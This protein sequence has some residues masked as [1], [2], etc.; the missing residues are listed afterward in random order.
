MNTLLISVQKDLDIIG[1][2]CLHYYLLKNGY[3]S[4]LLHL[5][6]FNPNDE[7]SL[8][9]VKNFISE[10]SPL[11]I[12]ISLM[13][14]EYYNARDLTKYLKAN[15]KSIPIIWGGIHPSISPE[16]CLA[17]ADYVCVG[18]GERTILDFAN[19]INNHGCV[20][21]INN[22]C[23][24]ENNR[25]K[26]NMLYP[27]IEDLDNIPSYDHIPVN[28]FI[29]NEKGLIIP[30]DK[31]VFRKYA[32]Y[33]GTFYS[34]MS[35]RGCPFS[36]TYCCNNFLSR[37]YQTKKVRRRSNKNIIIELEKAVKDNPEIEYINFQDDCFLACGDEYLKEFCKLYKEK[38]KKPFVVRAIPIYI[39]KNKIKN[40]KEAGLSWISLGLQSG[41]DR[42]CKDIYK[43]KSLK[44]DFLKAAKIIKE[45]NIAAF[46]DVIL[47]NP[48]ETEE[49]GLETIQTLIETPKPFYTQFFSLSLYLGTELYE[50]AQKECP[51]KIEDSLKKKYFL[52]HKK[53]INNMIRYSTFLSGKFMNKVVYLYKQDPK[54][55]RFRVILFIANLL[56]SLVFEP[57]TYFRVIKLSQGNSYIRTFK[58]LPNYFKE[59]IMRYFNQ[60][61]AKR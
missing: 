8:K 38:V 45:F 26:K 1:L 48:F 39:T 50:K 27:P 55:L 40:L 20:E 44:A 29:Q 53:T 31:K 60:F 23:Y 12:G 13:S 21:T 7:N 51:E 18:E 49:D 17:D 52:Y 59:G 28:S 22:L 33:K 34:I 57:L 10:I 32:R 19:A 36:C 5:I 14:V 24:I 42:I 30:I 25:I 9:T 2:K 15:F 54:G 58:V 6:N 46:Y 47:D 3:N 56:S 4:F 16:M 43:R 41:S 61:K 37:L 11:F 35:S